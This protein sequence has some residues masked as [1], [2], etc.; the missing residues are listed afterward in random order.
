M[1]IITNNTRIV[2][3][4]ISEIEDLVVSREGELAVPLT[5]CG[6]EGFSIVKRWHGY[7]GKSQLKTHVAYAALQLVVKKCEQIDDG[8]DDLTIK[9]KRLLRPM[10]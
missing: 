9:S 5:D 7:D 10:Q 3:H 4:L 2:F 8:D 6:F 1:Q